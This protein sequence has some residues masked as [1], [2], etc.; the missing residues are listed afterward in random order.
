MLQYDE[1]DKVLHEVICSLARIKDR[2]IDAETAKMVEYE[3]PGLYFTKIES[4]VAAYN[5]S[6]DMI[7][8]AYMARKR[9]RDTIDKT[10]EDAKKKE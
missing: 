4:L 7:T 10:I 3:T 9:L 1:S 2:S 6:V 5:K 8:K